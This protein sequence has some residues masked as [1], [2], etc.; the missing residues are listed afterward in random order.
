M[1]VKNL[2]FSSLLTFMLGI[3]ACANPADEEI[4]S[5]KQSFGNATEICESLDSE[6]PRRLLGSLHVSRLGGQCY[7][8]VYDHRS[9]SWVLLDEAEDGC[10]EIYATNSLAVCLAGASVSIR[11]T[12]ASA[13]NQLAVR[14]QT[15]A[16][17]G[18]GSSSSSGSFGS[19][20]AR[21]IVHVAQSNFI[22]IS[23][24]GNVRVYAKI[25]HATGSNSSKLVGKAV[26]LD[27]SALACNE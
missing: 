4:A 23:R 15:E 8:S 1:N 9:Q 24:Q 19:L 10:H 14:H 11:G 6:T 3:S 2:L 20:G 7:F 25:E 5:L 13:C 27:V 18:D 12:N 22:G 17:S 26:W 21:S 16:W